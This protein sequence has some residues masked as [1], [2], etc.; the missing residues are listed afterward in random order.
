MDLIAFT[1]WGYDFSWLEI[2]GL[3]TGLLAVYLAGRGRVA[4]FF[5]GLIN[6]AIFFALFWQQHLYSMML[7]QVFFFA[8]DIYGIVAWGI[9]RKNKPDKKLRISTLQPQHQVGLG[10]GILFGGL[11][12]GWLVESVTERFDLVQSKYLYTDAIIFVANVVGQWLL[13]RKKIEN[14]VVWILVDLASVVLCA[15]SSIYLTSLLYV[16]YVAISVY[17]LR[18]WY[19]EME[20]DKKAE[21]I[22][23]KNKKKKN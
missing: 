20:N 5:V 23:H 18:L 13:A 4:T 8:I 12:W 6:C 19:R 21:K 14:W 10:L 7:M 15:L 2:A 22:A 17:A 11:L 1:L 9:P 3:L 16:G